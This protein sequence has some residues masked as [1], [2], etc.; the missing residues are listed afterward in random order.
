MTRTLIRGLSRTL[1]LLGTFACGV[2]YLY[3][4]AAQKSAPA[5]PPDSGSFIGEYVLALC[6]VGV[7]LFAVCSPSNKAI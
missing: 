5:P 3:A 6:A 7:V 4:Q 1:A 2:S